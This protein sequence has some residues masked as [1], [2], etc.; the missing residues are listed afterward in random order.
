[1]TRM[2][3]QIPNFTYPDGDPT[4]IFD[5][6]I[7]QAKAAEAS[8]FDRVLVMDHF[9][10]LPGI[11]AP[12]EP[13]FECYS[14]LTA[15]AQG[16]LVHQQTGR[17]PLTAPDPSAQLMQLR[18][19]EGFGAFDHHNRGVGHIH[20]DFDHGGCH[21]NLARTALK[22]AHGGVFFG[23]R[24]LS[25]NERHDVFAQGCPQPLETVFSG[26]EVTDLAFLHKRTHP[27]ALFAIGHRSPP[28]TMGRPPAK[29]RSS[30]PAGL[31]SGSNTNAVRQC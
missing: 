7:A 18:K 17:R 16:V 19:P 23:G 26:N 24:H 13:M 28:E 10:Q 14:L 21:Q 22:R 9:Y 15:L 4:K 12:D 30:D 29:V 25:V 5:A 3:Y 11:G 27:V 6:V 2:G 1:M 20:T 8:G 31:I